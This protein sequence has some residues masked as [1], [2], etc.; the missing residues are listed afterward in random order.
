MGRPV[1]SILEMILHRQR[2]GI[3]DLMAKFQAYDKNH[4]GRIRANRFHTVIKDAFAVELS[5]EELEEIVS[6]Y[7]YPPTRPQEPAMIDY[8]KFWRDIEVE[9]KVPD[10][11]RPERPQTAGIPAQVKSQVLTTLNQVAQTVRAQRIHSDEMLGFFMDFD[12][13]KRGKVSE[14]QFINILNTKMTMKLTKLELQGL[15]EVFQD[16][17]PGAHTNSQLNCAGVTIS[18]RNFLEGVKSAVKQLASSASSSQQVYYAPV[19]GSDQPAAGFNHRP[20]SRLAKT[21][22]HNM[23][24]VAASMRGDREEFQLPGT[25]RVETRSVFASAGAQM[26]ASPKVNQAA[27]AASQYT[28]PNTYSF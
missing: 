5:D 22:V 3:R 16:R 7:I 14:Q 21:G 11:L 13:F 17:S 9:Q 2:N 28:D 6:A 12:K 26:A 18:Y 19:G 25:Q 27:P 4:S 24:G 15:V 8:T 1:Y 20:S 23:T 10:R